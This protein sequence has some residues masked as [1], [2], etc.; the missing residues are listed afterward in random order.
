MWYEVVDEDE[1]RAMMKRVDA[2]LP[3]TAEDQVDDLTGTVIASAGTGALGSGYNVDRT[4]TLRIR[5]GS[6]TDG[7]CADAQSVL[8]SMGYKNFD[9]GNADSF[10][11]DKT[12][13]VYKDPNY[14]NYANQIVEAFGL[15]KAVEDDGDY[16]FDSD[17]L[18]IIGSDWQI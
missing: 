12:I 6:G 16:L 4:A 5:N 3:P 17:F 8:E 1:W 15:G 18:I 11:Y 2:G 13:V 10:D 14:E 9:L 7:V